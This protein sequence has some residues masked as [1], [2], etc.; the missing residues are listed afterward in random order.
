MK[1]LPYFLSLC[2]L[3]VTASSLSAQQTKKTYLRDRK[4]LASD[5]SMLVIRTRDFVA[6]IAFSRDG[7][8]LGGASGR[9]V[10]FWDPVNGVQAAGYGA[11]DEIRAIDFDPKGGRVVYACFYLGPVWEGETHEEFI[12][13]SRGCALV[14]DFIN[15]NY[16]KLETPNKRNI[17]C[18][19][20]SFS[21]GGEH[22]IST[23]ASTAV[24][25]NATTGDSVLS[26]KGND[27]SLARYSPDGSMIAT[28]GS[29]TLIRIWD[30]ATGDLIRSFPIVKIHPNTIRFSPDGRRIVTASDSASRVWNVADGTL[31]LT[32]PH[33][34]I[35]SAADYSSDGGW[36]ITSGYDHNARIW[37]A[38]TGE[39]LRT[40]IG[41]TAEVA[42][43]VFSP[44]GTRAATAGADNT[45]RIWTLSQHNSGVRRDRNG[46]SPSLQSIGSAG[47][48]QINYTIAKRGPVRLSLINIMGQEVRVM[49]NTEM[50]PGAY[51]VM[52]PTDDLPSGLYYCILQAAER[53][54]TPLHV[55][56]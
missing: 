9:L 54:I 49:V 19:D 35:V 46:K 52:I 50:E 27:I 45:I 23:H 21:P 10:E 7:S 17:S 33:D 37:D 40:M 29:D 4:I 16:Q 13:V 3:F 55:R 18:I 56:R 1:I 34:N 44:D 22:I 12:G 41:H 42:S 25:W 2:A 43:A 26:L 24:I 36:I 6:P 48:N 14:Y 20:A 53:T 8:M 15:G 31:L 39:L 5:D 28:S 32:L 38:K 51:S 30:A 11:G 47:Q